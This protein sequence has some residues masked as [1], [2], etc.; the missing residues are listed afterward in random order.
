MALLLGVGLG[1]LAPWLVQR[2]RSSRCRPSF[3]HQMLQWL[4]QAPVGVLVLDQR[5][6]FIWSTARPVPCSISREKEPH[7]NIAPC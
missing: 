7:G 6:P 2:Q 1:L 3:D 4:R 5:Q